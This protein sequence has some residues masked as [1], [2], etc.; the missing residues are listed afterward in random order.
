MSAPIDF[1]LSNYKYFFAGD[2]TGGFSAFSLLPTDQS[3]QDENVS[4]I[5]VAKAFGN[6]ASS[7]ISC[8]KV[9][10]NYICLGAKNGTLVIVDVKKLQIHLTIEKF[11]ESQINQ[12]ELCQNYLVVGGDSGMMRRVKVIEAGANPEDNL[13]HNSVVLSTKTEN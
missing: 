4:L 12:I 11:M 9:L 3:K 5:Q 10:G 1:I 2:N 8:W 13:C 7:P 6:V